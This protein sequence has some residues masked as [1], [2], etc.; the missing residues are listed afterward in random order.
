[1]ARPGISKTMAIKN[2]LEDRN[3][4]LQLEAEQKQ[5]SMTPIFEEMVKKLRD[6]PETNKELLELLAA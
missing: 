1:M 3:V 6:D 5:R 2:G 4:D